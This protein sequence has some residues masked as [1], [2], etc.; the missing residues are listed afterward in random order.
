M[1]SG[2]TTDD[3]HLTDDVERFWA[4]GGEFLR[5]RPAPH[6]VHLTVTENLR[7]RGARLYGDAD[8]EFGLLAGEGGAAGVR[9]AFLR[10]PP[11]PVVLTSLTEEEA[12]VLAAR[13]AG[14]GR[15]VSGVSADRDTAAAFAGAWRR[16]TGAEVSLRQ[17]MRLYRLGELT[18]PHPVPPGRA[19][20]AGE[21]DRKLLARWYEEFCAAVGETA[22]Q[23][24]GKWADERVRR[25]DVMLWQDPDGTPVAMAGTTP[26]VAGQV[27]VAGVYTP[28]HL[29]GR[30]YAG[31]VTVEVSRAARES[32]AEEVL[33]FTDLANPTSNGLYQRIGYRPVSD[34]AV[35]DFG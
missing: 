1:T 26:K 28:A 34:F 20:V 31:A 19:T 24:A 8:P 23:D 3:W 11:H 35:Y 12:A 9:A 29:R 14:P 13:L 30:G 33:L 25:A 16:L 21:A 22:V 17:R 10:T 15:E 27:R 18:V 6:T 7:S 5:S 2:T 32:G 4:R